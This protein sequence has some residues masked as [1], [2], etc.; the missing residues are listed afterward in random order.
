MS[1]TSSRSAPAAF[2]VAGIAFILGGIVQV[3]W[4]HNTGED[5]VGFGGYA[6]LSLLVVSLLALAP[7]FLGLARSTER[8]G[9]RIGGTAAAIG[10]GVLGLVCITSIANGHDLSLFVVL[11]PIT[12][13]AWFFGSIALA[14][15]LR[16]ARQIPLWVAIAMPLTQV[17]ALPLSA[18]GGGVVAGA[19]WIAVARQLA[20]ATTS[21]PQAAPVAVAAA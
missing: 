18:V 7:G 15:S 20:A 16:R 8:R 10:T 21:A 6:S 12:N 13:A 4:G 1:P 14:V 5:V 19:L 2:V 9:A 17:F 11:A 3:A